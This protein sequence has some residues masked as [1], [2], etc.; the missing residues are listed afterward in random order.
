MTVGSATLL[1]ERTSLVDDIIEETLILVLFV[2]NNTILDR[3]GVWTFSETADVAFGE[4]VVFEDISD[5]VAPTKKSEYK[6][7]SP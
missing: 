3:G 5:E 2:L 6:A 4:G 1:T 7:Q